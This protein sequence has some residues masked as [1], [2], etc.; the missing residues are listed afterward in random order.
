MALK[1]LFQKAGLD[2]F[3]LDIKAYDENLYKK[4]CGTQNKTVL[5]SPKEILKREFLLEV[6]TVY[7]PDLIEVD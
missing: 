7:I 6:L 3:W 4:L 1:N 5:S 2:S